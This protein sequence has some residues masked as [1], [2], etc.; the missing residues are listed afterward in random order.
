MQNYHFPRKETTLARF[1]GLRAKASAAHIRTLYI[2]DFIRALDAPAGKPA[3][4]ADGTT[5]KDAG[6]TQKTGSDIPYAGTGHAVDKGGLYELPPQEM[7]FRFC[8]S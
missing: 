6:G 2:K 5:Y 3:A 7:C 1:F 4:K 8:Q